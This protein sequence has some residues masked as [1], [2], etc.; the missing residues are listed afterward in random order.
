MDCR[1]K[2]GNDGLGQADRR[3]LVSVS[4]LVWVRR[5]LIVV[6]VNDVAEDKILGHGTEIIG[7]AQRPQV[8]PQA[9]GAGAWNQALD[10][11]VGALPDRNRARE[12]RA[13]RGRQLAPAAASVMGVDHHRDEPA[14]LQR[15][16]RGGERGA[17][18]GKQGRDRPDAGRLGPVQRHH[19]RILSAGQAERPQRVVE[20]PRERARRALQVKAQARVPHQERGGEGNFRCL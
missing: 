20:T 14:P 15:L 1:V 12:Q 10:L 5:R 19:R 3:A 8:P 9:L 2:P 17:V 16:E 13:A 7:L 18:H 4:S 6:E 11:G